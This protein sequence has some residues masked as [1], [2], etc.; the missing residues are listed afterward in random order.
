M[1]NL[2][3]LKHWQLFIILTCMIFFS[4]F[5][6][7]SGLKIRRFDSIQLSNFVRVIGVIILFLWY[8]FFGLSLNN[9]T[10]NPH[11]FKSGLFILAIIFC[12][13]GYSNM[14]LQVIF[15]ENYIVP[16]FVSMLSTPLT[17]L[18]LIYVFYNL[19]ISLKS[20]EINRKAGFSDC[21]LDMIL[22]FAFPVGIWIIQPRLNKLFMTKKN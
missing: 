4:I 12:A 10:D 6:A 14:N 7:E 11:K 21:V 17:L 22:L 5:V 13:F 1:K 3:R 15:S 20:L 16:N 19:P 2:F 9:M 8:L 18:G